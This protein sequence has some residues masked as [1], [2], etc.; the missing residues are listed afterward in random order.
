MWRGHLRYSGKKRLLNS[1]NAS[2][3]NRNNAWTVLFSQCHL[4]SIVIMMR[5]KSL[6]TLFFPPVI[7]VLSLNS[8]FMVNCYS[9][10][11][12]T[13]WKGLYACVCAD[14]DSLFSSF[15]HKQTTC[16]VLAEE[17]IYSLLTLINEK[18]YLNLNQGIK[19]VALK[20]Q[21]KAGKHTYAEREMMRMESNRFLYLKCLWVK[22]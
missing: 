11:R 2:G 8:I 6:L 7:V 19:R 4:F 14:L 12:Q 15:Y 22:Y 17:P 20:M 1:A 9:R 10:D 5:G 3:A 16:S 18:C 21:T 13:K